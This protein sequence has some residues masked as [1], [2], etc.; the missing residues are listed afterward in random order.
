MTGV[1]VFLTAALGA[2]AG[3]L[4]PGDHLRTVRLGE[5]SRPYL[6]HVPISYDPARPHPVVLALHPFATNGAVMARIT[7]LSDVADREKF[8]IAYPEGRGRAGILHWDVEAKTGGDSDDVAY[9]AAVLDDIAD[10]AR[11]DPKRIFATGFSNG[12]MMCYRLASELSGRIAAIAAVAGTMP[13][14]EIRASRPVPVLHFH[15]TRDGFV[16]YDG[17]LWR[18]PGESRLKGVEAT[19]RAWARFDGCPEMPTTTALPRATAESLAVVKSVYGPGR[20]GSS[21]ILYRIEEGG[22]AWPGRDQTGAFLG[23]SAADLKANDLIWEF[24]RE[25]PLP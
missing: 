10:V 15:G 14:A 5:S 3:P 4:T 20:E 21:V 11:V 24:F 19:V 17:R 1:A 23:K 12:A 6:L 18:N 13:D 7:G 8:L 25:H 2:W 22:H 9:L 16:S